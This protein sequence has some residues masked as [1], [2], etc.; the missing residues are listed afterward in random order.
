MDDDG[1]FLVAW[2]AR[3]AARAR[4]FARRYDGLGIPQAAVSEVATAAGRRGGLRVV[5]VAMRPGGE[6][7]VVWDDTKGAVRGRQFD[8]SG[9]V[10]GGELDLLPPY[11]YNADAALAA[12]GTFVVVSS[13]FSGPPTG[14]NYGYSTSPWRAGGAPL[15]PDGRADRG[16]PPRFPSVL[17]EG[18]DGARR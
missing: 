3:A 16:L 12:D 2:T 18:G 6:A 7:L 15:R 1:G 17:R 9:R 13:R 11:S 4:V 10:N 14:D 5:S 8:S